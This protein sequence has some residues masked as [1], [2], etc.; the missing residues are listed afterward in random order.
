MPPLLIAMAIAAALSAGAGAIESTANNK[1]QKKNKEEIG[2]LEALKKAGGFGLNPVEERQMQ[3]ELLS[4]VQQAAAEGRARAEQ[5]AA[6][7]QNAS[8]ADLSRLRTEQQRVV[9]EGG[10]RA[11]T[12]VR[13]ADIAKA[14]AQKQELEGRYQA[15]A[16]MKED[17]LRAILGG[18]A[19]GAQGAGSAAALPPIAAAP[20]TTPTTAT[21]MSDQDLAALI[22]RI[23]SDPA[24]K[25]TI[26][27][28]LSATGAYGS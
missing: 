19:K 25:D 6:S 18:L 2:N 28:S 11:V 23:N 22:Q 4:P 7:A 21:P 13:A 24:L 10:Q 1:V 3:E 15:Q 20:T 17:D 16:G 8:G 9:G 26:A 5:L 27:R 14:A 12:Q